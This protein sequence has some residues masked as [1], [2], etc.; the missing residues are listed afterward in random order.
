MSST[1]Y[2]IIE[3]IP[4]AISPEKGNL[5]QLSAIRLKGLEL[6]DRFDYRIAEEMI[7]NRDVKEMVCYN[8][9]SFH[10]V[11][12]TEEILKSFKKWAKNT[13]LLILDNIY[14]N[15][16]LKD[17]KN[18]KEFIGKYLNM[19]YTDDFIDKVIEKYNL[20]PSN[21][22]VDLLYEALIYESNIK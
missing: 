3:L 9:E 5:V 16:F 1:Q 12:S 8:K 21:Y 19:E 20:E 10:Y 17:I 18:K 4:E 2:I 6:L 7:Q 15:N 11:K 14:T 13:N 22:I